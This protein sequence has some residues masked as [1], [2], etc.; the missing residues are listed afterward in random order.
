MYPFRH[1]CFTPVSHSVHRGVCSVHAGILPRSRHLPEN[2][3]PSEQTPP[4]IDTTPRSIHPSPTGTRHPLEQTP[5]RNRHPQGSVS[6]EIRSTRGQYAS[7]WNAILFD[8][9]YKWVEG[10]KGT[11]DCCFGSGHHHQWPFS[12]GP[13][14]KLRWW[15]QTPPRLNKKH[16]SPWVWFSFTGFS[17]VS[18]VSF[19]IHVT[20]GI[21]CILSVCLF[22]K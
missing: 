1:D 5:P 11:A 8:Y 20:F 9:V 19:K 3:L 12:G 10:K 21:A 17:S 4:G 14:F 16:V 15:T 2:S 13:E 22:C 18:I 6:S 7:Y